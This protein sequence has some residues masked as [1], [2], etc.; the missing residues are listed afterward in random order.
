MSGEWVVAFYFAPQSVVPTECCVKL[1]IIPESE[2][3]DV[4]VMPEAVSAAVRR[5]GRLDG[6]YE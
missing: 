2:W 3:Q 6:G 4:G 1:K 5:D